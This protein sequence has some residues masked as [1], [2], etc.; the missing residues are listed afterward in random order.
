MNIR[1]C[2]TK[3]SACNQPSETWTSPMAIVIYVG[4]AFA[5]GLAAGS[6]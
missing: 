3:L 6:K 1:T 4:T 2:E 5:I